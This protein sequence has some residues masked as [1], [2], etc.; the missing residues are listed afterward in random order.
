MNPTDLINIENPTEVISF[1]MPIILVAL[2]VFFLAMGIVLSYHWRKYGVGRV[3]A[4]IFMW[5]YLIG[6]II[7]IGAMLTAKLSY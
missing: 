7:F 4:A 2:A 1:A 6:G 3:K 5:T